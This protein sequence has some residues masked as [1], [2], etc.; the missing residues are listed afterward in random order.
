VCQCDIIA[1]CH[2]HWVEIEVS[3]RYHFVKQVERENMIIRAFSSPS[4]DEGNEE[5]KGD[6][7]LTVTSKLRA[8]M[9][10][11][12]WRCERL[13]RHI[14]A[15]DSLMRQNTIIERIQHPVEGEG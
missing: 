10:T 4:V 14:Q 15:S 3:A 11:D 5:Q 1:P 12:E 7:P 13:L 6:P 9:S 2:F 8:G